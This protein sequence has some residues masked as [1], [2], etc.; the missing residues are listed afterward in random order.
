[1]NINE[2]IS[3]GIIEM[4]VMGLCNA[5]EK[6]ELET[7]RRQHPVLHEA[8]VQYEKEMEE[9]MRQQIT[10]PSAETDEKILKS[11]DSLQTPLIPIDTT[12]NLCKVDNKAFLDQYGADKDSIVRNITRAFAH[13]IF[14]DGFYTADPHPG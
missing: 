10:L 2:Y 3:S 4:Y 6:Q 13:Q 1:M 9:K 11:F 5:E 14:V 7:L 12:F 8:I